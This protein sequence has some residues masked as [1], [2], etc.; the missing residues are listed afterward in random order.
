MEEEK[1]AKEAEAAQK[2]KGSKAKKETAGEDKFAVSL[3]EKGKQDLSLRDRLRAEFSGTFVDFMSQEARENLPQKMKRLGKM[4]TILT[5]AL[6]SKV[7]LDSHKQLEELSILILASP[8]NEVVLT[9]SY[10]Q[11]LLMLT[12]YALFEYSEF[13]NAEVRKVVDRV[14]DNLL[15][16]TESASGSGSLL[17]PP[18]LENISNCVCLL[19]TMPQSSKFFGVCISIIGAG[20]PMLINQAVCFEALRKIGTILFTN[21]VAAFKKHRRK[22]QAEEFVKVY[23]LTRSVVSYEED[24]R[25]LL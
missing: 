17:F 19:E 8:T 11:V 22:Q 18:L 13:K 10:G 24:V 1:Y 15:K 14:K 4:F 7:T 6:K 21:I 23:E 9:Y 20:L 2:K 3:T 25:R 16:F 12:F 5:E